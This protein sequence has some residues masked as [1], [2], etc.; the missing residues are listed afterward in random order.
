[1]VKR[2]LIQAPI[3][4]LDG[5]VIDGADGGTGFGTS[6][7]DGCGVAGRITTAPTVGDSAFHPASHCPRSARPTVPPFR[8]P[9]D[10]QKI[11][12]LGAGKAAAIDEIGDA[13]EQRMVFFSEGR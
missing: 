13:A 10:V 3:E 7:G 2:D 6:G 12:G 8:C 4:P 1:L 9:G 11:V 5:W